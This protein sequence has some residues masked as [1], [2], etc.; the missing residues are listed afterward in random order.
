MNYVELANAL[1]MLPALLLFGNISPSICLETN[2]SKVSLFNLVI[3][4]MNYHIC[5]ALGY[6][7]VIIS[8]A[9]L[10]DLISQDI[11]IT[12]IS[13]SYIGFPSIISFIPLPLCLLMYYNNGHENMFYRALRFVFYMVYGYILLNDNPIA[14]ITLT[15]SC[16]CY[17]LAKI[18]P[19]R[20]LHSLFHSF[21]IAAL[22][23]IFDKTSYCYRYSTNIHYNA[24][25]IFSIIILSTVISRINFKA[26]LKHA[27]NI[28]YFFIASFYSYLSLKI[29]HEEYNDK[30]L[31]EQIENRNIQELLAYEQAYYIPYTIISILDKDHGMT[32][33]HIITMTCIHLA[34]IYS[35]HQSALLI[36]TL[37]SLSTPFLTLAKYCYSIER[38]KCSKVSFALFTIIF[39][40]ARI[41]RFTQLIY[42][43][44]TTGYSLVGS[45]INKKVYYLFN[46]L[47]LCLYVLQIIWFKKILRILLKP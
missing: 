22:K 27:E 40:Y 37:F 12:F 29:Y 30:L 39:C 2:L 36:L 17:M 18:H 34:D 35:Y 42:M 38:Y 25:M 9:C 26:N 41:I 32:F 44:V 20:I 33:H 7:K 5:R 8:Q 13:I 16:I 23:F 4:S 6:N 3:C 11:F 21:S 10:L 47:L 46:I 24:L 1:T 31:F 45:K 43:I 15:C 14:L 28:L 19:I